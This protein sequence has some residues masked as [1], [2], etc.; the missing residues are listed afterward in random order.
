MLLGNAA[1]MSK[2]Y[3]VVGKHSL[4]IVPRYPRYT[5]VTSGRDGAFSIH[6]VASSPCLKFHATNATTFLKFVPHHM[7]FRKSMRRI[8]PILVLNSQEAIQRRVCLHLICG[9]N[10]RSN[11]VH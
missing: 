7:E 2:L 5:R 6:D 11:L 8:H 4:Y 9:T 1:L 10:Y 3:A